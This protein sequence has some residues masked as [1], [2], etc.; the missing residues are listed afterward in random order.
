MAGASRDWLADAEGTSR[1][2]AAE[3]GLSADA[4]LYGDICENCDAR[5]SLSADRASCPHRPICEDC[6]PNGCEACEWQEHETLK[7]R[8]QAANRIV[9]AALE[10]RTAADDL[11]DADLHSLDWITRKDVKRHIA[12]TIE[13][14][15]RVRDVLSTEDEKALEQ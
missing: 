10:I 11:N 5:W 14:L 2:L 15:R 7:H 8:E 6:Y 1:R 3:F 4:G 12:L 13:A 9:S